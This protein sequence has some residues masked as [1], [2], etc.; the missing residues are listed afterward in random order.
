MPGIVEVAAL[1]LLLAPAAGPDD[2]DCLACHGDS[3]AKS[4]SGRSV[5]VDEKKYHAGVHSALGCGACHE[6]VTPD[7][8]HKTQLPRPACASCHADAADA[9]R[10]SVHGRVSGFP[11]AP[12]CRSCHASAHE[13][14]ALGDSASPVGKGRLPETCGQ[15]HSNP[16]FLARHRIPFARPVE[17]YRLSVHGRAVE[18]GNAAAPA[19]SNCHDS[20]LILPARD[21]RSTINHWA[22]TKTCASCHKEIGAAYGE[23][24]HGRAVRDGVRAAP[25]CT[26]CHGE[27]SILA[28]SEPLSLV[29]PARVSSVTCGH[30]HA[31][32]RLA[33]RYNLPKDRVPAFRD[34]FHGL[35]ARAGSQRVAN[36]AS[37]HG[38]H[39]ILPSSDA[40]ST[41][42]PANLAKTCGACHP[43][44]G[45]RFTIGPVHV[46]PATASEHA[47]VRLIRW[48]YLV[49]IP[50]SVAFMVLHNALDFIA[51]LVRGGRRH[52]GPTGEVQRMTLHFRVAHGLV[53]LSFP[54]LVVTGFALKYPEAWWAAPLLA[55]EGDFG[56]RGWLHRAA[57]VA[58]LASLLYH[59]VHLALS[60]RDRVMLRAMLP[61]LQDLRDLAALTRFNLGRVQQRPHFG[62]FSYAE[63]LEYWAFLWGS[64]VMAASGFPLW[65]NDLTL[66]FLPTW[67]AD[68]AT[69]I[70]WYEAILATLSIVIWHFYMVIFDPDVYPME[71]A[72]ITGRVPAQ[73]LW[74]TRPAYYRALMRETAPAD[75]PSPAEATTESAQA[76]LPPTGDEDPDG[77]KKGS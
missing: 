65:F 66:R 69:A 5:F 41:V 61:R 62:K 70:H 28:A 49:L 51:K 72:W 73:Q 76:N 77:G 59:F 60:P 38:V 48:A 18:R 13:I 3:E 24:V 2:S 31:D 17:A 35:A 63:K 30:C 21:P 22:V 27:H 19:C 4:D 29:N 67:V 56:L 14:V 23:S 16:D 47:V 37:C 43:G 32:E 39:N 52:A 26:D 15:C 11:D 36:C 44:A 54:T 7:F 68:A 74:Q 33:E 6:G 55:W 53:V 46:R 71:K 9:L 75:P 64:V 45:T 57:A 12:E 25:V 50:L 40:R 34:S 10:R 58:L 42:H 8:P 1:L 20:H